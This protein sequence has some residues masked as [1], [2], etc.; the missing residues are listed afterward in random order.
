VLDEP[1][2]HLDLAAREQL[3]RVLEDY[4]GTIVAVSHDRYFIDRLASEIWDIQQAGLKRYEGGWTAF[5]KARD[6]GRPLPDP[7]S[8]ALTSGRPVDAPA[9]PKP[10]KAPKPAA[11]PARTARPAPA[12]RR[13][14]S[15]VR[16]VEGVRALEARIAAMELQLGQ[17]AKKLD[18]VAQ[19]GNFMETRQLGSEHAE[20]E[21][22]LR[23]LY[24]EWS[25]VAEPSD[26]EA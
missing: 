9:R 22:S 12:T 7:D 3:E 26:P 1:T 25:A 4:E 21:S 19:S 17:L 23:K 13:T 20:L 10:A 5:E 6:E 11:R 8:T 14:A 24:E 15:R 18:G 2:N 16:K